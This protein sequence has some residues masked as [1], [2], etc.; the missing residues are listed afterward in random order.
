MSLTCRNEEGGLVVTHC[1]LGT[2]ESLGAQNL[3]SNFTDGS[4]FSCR[5]VAAMP[6]SASSDSL[7]RLGQ[8]MRKPNVQSVPTR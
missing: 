1:I 8:G 7:D 6:K 5:N 3:L 4:A 2:L